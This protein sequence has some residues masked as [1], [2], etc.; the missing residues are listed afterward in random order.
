MHAALRRAPLRDREAPAALRGLPAPRRQPA[1]AAAGAPR[2]VPG[3]GA[4]PAPAGPDG[5]HKQ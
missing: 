4:E 3:D 2:A 1:A 5:I